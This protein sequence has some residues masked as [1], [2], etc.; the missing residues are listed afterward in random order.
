[1]SSP[2]K[3]VNLQDAYMRFDNPACG[4]V[5]SEVPEVGLFQTNRDTDVE[6][7]EYTNPIVWF[8]VLISKRLLLLLAVAFLLVL[9]GCN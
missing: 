5:I 2:A 6:T 3:V 9:A 8:V 1:M 7:R 4:W